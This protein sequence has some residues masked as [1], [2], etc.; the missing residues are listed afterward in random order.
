[1]LGLV[2]G[3]KI[4]GGLFVLGVIVGDFFVGYFDSCFGLGYFVY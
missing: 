3:F 1:M 4:F 2:I